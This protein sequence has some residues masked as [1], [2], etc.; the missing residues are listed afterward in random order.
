[1]RHPK[2]HGEREGAGAPLEVMLT[3][4]VVR[5]DRELAKMTF[6]SEDEEVALLEAVEDKPLH[7]TIAKEMTVR[8]IVRIVSGWWGSYN[9]IDFLCILLR[10]A[11]VTLTDFRLLLHRSR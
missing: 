4:V 9:A 11:M 7:T 8:T 2:V 10:C 5:L 3:D 6:E 1:M